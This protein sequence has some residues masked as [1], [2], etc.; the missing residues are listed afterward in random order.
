[1]L[2]ELRV[3]NLLLIERAELRL[4]P[5]LNVITGETGA[6]KTV[7]A[8]ALDLLLGGKARTGIVRPG[9]AEAYVEGVF[10][11]PAEL[12]TT[13][14]DA[15]SPDAEELVLARRVGASGRTRALVNGRSATAGDLRDIGV[16]LLS[17]YGQHEHR[18]LTLGSAQ[19]DILDGYCGPAQ[20]DLRRRAS[21]AHDTARDARAA[22]DALRAD[23]GARERELDLLRFELDEIDLAAPDPGEHA[24]LLAR[25][26]RLRHLEAL[27]AAALGAGEAL[28]PEDGPGAAELLSAGGGLLDGVDGVDADLDALAV[29]WRAVALEATDLGADLR[30]YAEG[31]EGD[32]GALEAVEERLEVLDRLLRKHGGTIEAVLAHAHACRLRIAEQGDAD[33]RAGELEARL[34]AALAEQDAVGRELR[35]ARE[36]AGPRLARAVEGGLADLAMEG[37]RFE[38]RLEPREAGPAGSDAVEFLL[39][40]NSGVPAGPVR[41][42]ASGGELSRVM[43]ALLAIA[44][45]GPGSTLVFDEIDAGIGG[46]T[47][48][49]VGARLQTLAGERQVLC[50]TH[51][52]QVASLADRHFSIEKDP[53]ADP[54]RTTVT[55]LAEAQVVG[56]LVRMLGGDADDVGA[57][58]LA[59]ELRKAA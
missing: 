14:G 1:M 32:P 21:A 18:R 2:H 52:A 35:G 57:R 7:L 19:L 28:A 5:G 10:D 38:V 26:E 23:T 27:R 8:H 41:D 12:R 29:R 51:L 34:A 31:L 53:G 40:P 54:A 9:A 45:E 46:Q 33:A 25:R 17:F 3:E 59:R 13:L 44:G 36:A 16:A 39:A 22:L 15:V 6:G 58:R 56:E 50:I 42:A 4:A 11:L 24:E 30:R 43:L 37:A 48:R 47:A 20:L 55:Q 49:A